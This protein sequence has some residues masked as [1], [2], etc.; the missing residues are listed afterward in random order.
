MMRVPYPIELPPVPRRSHEF[1][2][3]GYPNATA[4]IGFRCHWH[5]RGEPLRVAAGDFAMVGDQ[6]MGRGFCQNDWLLSI[7][8]IGDRG[9]D[10]PPRRRSEMFR[11]RAKSLA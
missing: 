6:D 1:S 2:G 9:T 11:Q 3:I 4:W 8:D 7:A 5:R 10:H